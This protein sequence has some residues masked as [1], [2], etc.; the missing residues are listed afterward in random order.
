M[1]T[2]MSDS[3]R[4][5]PHLL[6]WYYN[7]GMHELL[8]IWKN[9]LF[10]AWQY[11]SISELSGTLLSPWR[12]DVTNS[13]WVGIHPV[14]SLALFFEN[15]ISRILGAIV[16]SVVI[17]IGL[18]FFLVVFIF[19]IIIAAL[20]IGAPVF[21]G[22]V[23]L[24]SSRLGVNVYHIVGILL[25]WLGSVGFF[26]YQDTKMPMHLVGFAQMLKHPVF[27][28]VCSRLGIARKRFP[29]EIFENQKLFN[30]FLKTRN[31]TEKEYL[32]I[33]LHEINRYQ[34]TKDAAKFWHWEYLKKIQ[35]IGMQWRYG[36]TVQ[37]DRYCYD[38][39][40]G[41]QSEYAKN[42]LIGRTE[43][44]EVMKLI[45]E[46]PD[47]NCVL[48]VGPAGI[49]KKNIIHA[50]ARNIRFNNDVSVLA[51]S[52][53]LILDL[54]RVISDA[55]SRGD[56]V[57]YSLRKLFFEAAY[58]GNVIL[59][60]EH[61]EYFLGKENSSFH[62]NVSAVLMEFL[63]AP[64]FQVI[65]L[66]TTKEYHQLIERQEDIA[67]YFEVIEMREPS[68]EDTVEILLNQLE[69][70]EHLRVL[71][72]FKALEKIVQDSS[73]H[74]WQFPLPERA[75]DLAMGV[76][77]FWEKKS[78]EE[79]VTEKTVSDYLSLKTGV[80]QG[81]IEGVERKKLLNLEEILHRQIIG[82]DEAVKQVSQAL[83][84]VRSGI[85]NSKK[86]VGSFLFLGPT[87][88]GKT[89]T[90]K[91]LAKAYF[92]DE[93]KMIRLDMSEFQTPS[94]IDR[95]LGSSQLNQ[96]G[97]LVTQIKDNPY[98]LLL[99]DEIEKAYPE[100]LD[101]FLQI[102]DEGYVNDAFGEKINFR[103]TMIIATSNAGSLLIKDM[104]EKESPAEEIKQ[105]VID[106]TIKNNLFRT[107][108]L[109]RFEG[110][111]FFR[112]LNQI[113]LK[114]VVRLQLQKFIRRLSKEKN[115]EVFYD[116]TIVEKIIERG[117]NPIFGARSL[118]RFIEDEL[119]SIV[120]RKIIAREVSPGEKISITL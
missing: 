49:G 88:V 30:D 115:I 64:S 19:G 71:F 2:I 22:A 62:S 46:R 82:Q 33:T 110:I 35:S 101:V 40:L 120:A 106:W 59:I 78:D 21:F 70:Y 99:L 11:F 41:D 87:G 84:R 29:N 39:S 112:P 89:E 74:N 111:V 102:L 27:E 72:T 8:E 14:K 42:E 38:L 80:P 68:E 73:K 105:A 3:V 92:G 4:K 91:A 54:G 95:L 31:M 23:F 104:V 28:R 7:Q 5:K 66:S 94:S 53:M 58:A 118:N 69:K 6:H 100:I 85:G 98:S 76:L 79:F 26:Y 116:E 15:I 52:R 24:Y 96:P 32:K 16:R 1:K 34:Q 45:L 86:P 55:I 61:F 113:E 60:I 107:E 50:L 97:R 17:A 119:E 13:N 18:C 56:D 12:R 63:N 10:F 77:M 114:S 117:Y 103:N 109:N 108:F 36:Y 25:A 90:A 43:E 9:F 75:I 67:K 65:A 81:E 37:L 93:E 47:Q 48:L 44:Y 83:R 20:W 51:N 57:E